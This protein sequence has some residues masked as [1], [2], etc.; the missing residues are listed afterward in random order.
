MKLILLYHDYCSLCKEML[1]ELKKYQTQYAF[2]I[3]II[4]IDSNPKLLPQYD[5]LVPVLFDE[6]YREICHYYLNKDALLLH[7]DNGR[8][9]D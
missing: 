9:T 8:K 5:E 2:D 6:Q 1:S 4:D 3:E 7:L